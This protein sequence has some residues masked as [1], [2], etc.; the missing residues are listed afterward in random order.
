MTPFT[1]VLQQGAANAW[2]FIPSAIVPGALHG[3]E[4]GHAK[5]LVAACVVAIRRYARFGAFMRMAPYCSGALMLTVGVYM[6]LQ[7]WLQLAARAVK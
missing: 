4:P 1:E 3:L 6:A 2:R 5:T 7:G